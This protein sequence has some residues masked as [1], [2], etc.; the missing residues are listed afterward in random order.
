MPLD[1]GSAIG[2]PGGVLRLI[3]DGRAVTRTDVMDM[4]GLSR[5]TVMQRLGVL[6]SAGLLVEQ[7]EAGRSSG[8][9][10]PAAL[11]FNERVGVVLAADLGAR[12]GRLAVC[13]L[14]GAALAERE[15]PLTIADGPDVVLDWVAR[16]FEALLA[17]A[18]RGAA[19]VLA[20]AIG[21]PGPVEAGRPANPPI[22]PGWDGYPVAEWLAER[23][24]APAL[25][26][27]DV[28][29]MALG[30]H[31]SHWRDLS[32][33]VFVKVAT[34]IGAGII[35]GGE[36]LRGNHGRAG[37]IGHIRAIRQS[38]V[39]CTCGNRGC[40]A[41]LATGS[42]MI[43]QLRE[44]GVEVA[45]AAD[46]VEL[47][48]AGDAV[49]MHQVREAGRV[50]GAAL[51]GVVSVVAPSLIV[52]G[53]QMAEASEPLLA[54]IRESVYQRASAL[55]TRELRILTSRIGPR[56]GVVGVTTLALEHVLEPANVD[57]LLARR[58]LAA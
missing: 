6:L 38:D 3:R 28:N 42:A 8:G 21:V 5:S 35:S 23:F 27:R 10:R 26:E 58:G 29:A 46:V 40:V 54:G 7:P 47:V 11:S 44:A 18:G 57:A 53:G 30:E 12:H 55:A 33:M 20:T 24:G 2:S 36:L 52:V 25:L 15:E 17:E 51:A 1:P 45:S 9:R 16:A 4:T 49:A 13:D 43:R 19:D 22:M 50:L 32:H 48:R 34:G 41:V 56:A 14:G 31:R 37:D 39:M